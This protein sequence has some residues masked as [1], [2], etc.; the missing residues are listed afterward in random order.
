VANTASAWA[1]EG[2]GVD[3]TRET[4]L[5]TITTGLDTDDMLDSDPP[6][7]RVQWIQWDS[8]FRGTDLRVEDRIVA[9]NGKR[10][11]KLSSAERQ[12][13]GPHSIGD[14][15]ESQYWSAQKAKDGAKVTLTVLRRAAS[16]QGVEEKEIEGKLLADRLYSTAKARRTLGPGGPEEL[17]NDGFDG[18]WAYWYDKQI[19]SWTLV[20]DGGWSSWTGHKF[21]SRSALAA[22]LEHKAR[23]DFLVSHYPGPFANSVKADW[24]A[25]LHSLEGRSYKIAAKDLKYRG[26]GEKQSEA[27][28]KAGVDARTAFSKKL[29]SK[30]IELPNVDPIRGDRRKVAGKVVVLPT[31]GPSNWVS[32]AGHCYLSAHSGQRWYFLDCN[33]PETRRMFEAE[34]RYQV[35]VKPRIS[36]RFDVIG[37]IGKDPKLVVVD[38]QGTLGLSIVPLGVTIGDQMFVDLTVVDDGASAFAGEAEMDKMQAKAPAKDASPDEVLQAFFA[39][40]K[41][42]DQTLWKKLFASWWAENWRD[43][44]VIYNGYYERHMDEEWIRARRLILD[45]VYDVRVIYQSEVHPVLTGKEFTKAPKI[46]EVTLEVD[47]IGKFGKEYRA[48]MD[49][50]VHR[51]WKLQ[52]RNGGAWRIADE[53][54]L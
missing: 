49:V 3:G 28:A 36:E 51:V 53:Q 1:G 10:F 33:D 32:E 14:S 44:G 35:L 21:N 25:V 48:Y 39:A 5:D 15:S 34:Q 23:V 8:G 11:K 41:A 19:E 18:A 7:L 46:D 37:R 20:L 6:A 29:E 40:L 22:H 54:G 30:I 38:G 17:S 4:V 9:L 45:A 52:R 16:G 43:Q 2:K 42:G 47:H 27:I 13:T 24:T 26:L 50:N 31:I 12:R